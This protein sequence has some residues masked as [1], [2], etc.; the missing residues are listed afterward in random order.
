MLA[1]NPATLAQIKQTFSLVF[2]NKALL[3]DQ[4]IEKAFA[5]KMKR[6]DGYTINQF[7]ESALRGE[8]FLDGKTKAIKAPT[9]V[10]WGRE[11]LLTP[12]AIGEAF[13]QD[14]P[15]AEKVVIDKCGHVPQ[16]ECAGPFHTALLKFL[17]GGSTA[18]VR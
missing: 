13:A 17:A 11:D 7:I 3:T 5:D 18:Q 16:L 8:D 14:I 10:L 15:G 12:L 2:H 6:G 1:L 9:L 4:F